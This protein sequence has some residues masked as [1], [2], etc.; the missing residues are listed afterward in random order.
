[1]LS[2][3]DFARVAG[4]STRTLRHYGEVGLLVPARVDDSS[5]YRYYDLAQL[6][7]LHRILAL[8]D[9]GIGLDE[10]RK[11]VADGVP[12]EQL[13]GMLRLRQ[14]EITAAVSADE[15]RL[16]RVAAHLDALERGDEVR[17]IDTVVKNSEPSRIAHITIA[18]QAYGSEHINP[19]FELHLPRLWEALVNSGVEPGIGVAY[20]EEPKGTD[21]IL[22]HVG[23][24]V[25]SQ[26]VPHVPGVTTV[27]LPPTE[28]VSTVHRGSMQEVTDL[29]EAL[30]R[31]IETSG[32]RI[33]GWP[34]E[35]YRHWAIPDETHQVTEFQIPVAR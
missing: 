22:V 28:V 29:F 20:Y 5:G 27:E 3:G 35:L 17:T 11:L 14:A 34:R 19:V 12:A 33:N 16:R 6:A 15:D 4:V 9:L 7:D 8:R 18:V 32:Y 21:D 25:G 31:W 13:R 2:I 1:M 10:I 30:V 26:A 24:D 23:Y